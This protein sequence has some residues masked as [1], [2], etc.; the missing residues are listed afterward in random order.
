MGLF[1]TFFF[2]PGS[3]CQPGSY[4]EKEKSKE[5]RENRGIKA[6]VNIEHRTL[7]SPSCRAVA[8]AKAEAFAKADPTSNEKKA[9]TKMQPRLEPFVASR[10]YP[11]PCYA[12]IPGLLSRHCEPREG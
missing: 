11:H 2:F 4:E 1:H 10:L 9:I 3:S 5:E 12:V 6:R 7:V 8:P